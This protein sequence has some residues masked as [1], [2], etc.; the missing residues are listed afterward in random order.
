MYKLFTTFLF[1]SI[2][3]NS[4]AQ[5]GSSGIGTGL[6]PGVKFLQI[7]DCQSDYKVQ[8]EMRV[9]SVSYNN[10]TVFEYR[11]LVDVNISLKSGSCNVEVA[12]HDAETDT[13]LLN[14]TMKEKG[15]QKLKE[16][17]TRKKESVPVDDLPFESL[18]ATGVTDQYIVKD[19][20]KTDQYNVNIDAPITDKHVKAI[21]DYGDGS[22]TRSPR[23]HIRNRSAK[24]SDYIT[25]VG[26]RDSTCDF[27]KIE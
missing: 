27:T 24:D 7:E 9:E 26:E 3:A 14:L 4:Y 16:I 5:T 25:F 12:I 11:K 13:K 21:I 8:C 19:L 6:P 15:I 10:E 1:I 2:S 18:E 17:G 23:L 22:S 20:I